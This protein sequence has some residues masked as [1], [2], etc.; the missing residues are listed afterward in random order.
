MQLTAEPI[1]IAILLAS[2]CQCYPWFRSLGP[3][4][5]LVRSFDCFAMAAD[6]FKIELSL[7]SS[8]HILALSSSCIG[9]V[10]LAVLRFYRP[11]S[12]YRSPVYPV[13]QQKNNMT[14]TC[15]LLYEVNLKAYDGWVLPLP[16]T[17][18][19]LHA[20]TMRSCSLCI[21][22]ARLNPSQL[23]E[24]SF[25]VFDYVF[26]FAVIHTHIILSEYLMFGFVNIQ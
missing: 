3:W 4:T 2:S 17:H 26:S 9:Q 24:T 25:L 16:S 11:L 20:R 1:K 23:K 5:I 7:C 14:A 19:V 18:F 6:I 8:A 15:L 21:W 12:L 13:E 10:C 22:L